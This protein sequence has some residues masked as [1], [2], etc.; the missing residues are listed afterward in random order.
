[1]ADC[2]VVVVQKILLDNNV[3]LIIDTLEFEKKEWN[4]LHVHAITNLFL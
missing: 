2:V 1:M 4:T 3:E